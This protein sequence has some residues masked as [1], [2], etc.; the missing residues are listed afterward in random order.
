MKE[1]KK[2]DSE[3]LVG[4]PSF[5]SS[6]KQVYWFVIIEMTVVIGLFYWFTKTFE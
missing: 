6:W 1:T 4:L 3:S 2:D 5:V